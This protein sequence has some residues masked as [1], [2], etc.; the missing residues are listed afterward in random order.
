[1]N[2]TFETLKITEILIP[3]GSETICFH[4]Q[5]WSKYCGQTRKIKWNWYISGIFYRRFL[6]NFK[7]NCG[8]VINS[9][10]LRDFPKITSDSDS[11]G[12]RQ[13]VRLLVNSPF[14]D[15]NLAP[16]YLWWKEIVLKHEKVYKYFVHVCWLEVKKTM[17]RSSVICWSL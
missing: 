9:K 14:G 2:E 12:V 10:F 13:L 7:H 16:I 15:N 3:Y 4:R 6:V 17:L 1:M 11:Y 5:L 8:L